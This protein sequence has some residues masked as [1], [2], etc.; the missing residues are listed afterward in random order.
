LDW[1]GAA[2]FDGDWKRHPGGELL[3]VA[4]GFEEV[5]VMGFME[6]FIEQQ[7]ADGI[8]AAA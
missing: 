6:A 7:L 3:D 5:V 2:C 8:S 4:P 1:V